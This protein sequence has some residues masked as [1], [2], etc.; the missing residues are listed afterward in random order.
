M[1]NYYTDRYNCFL[2]NANCIYEYLSGNYMND[3][4]GKLLDCGAFNNTINA[5]KISH[6]VQYRKME[7]DQVMLDT[8]RGAVEGYLSSI[9]RNNCGACFFIVSN[10]CEVKLYFAS[11]TV[12]EAGFDSVLKG[13]IPDVKTNNSFVSR[14]DLKR[15]ARYGGIVTG[16]FNLRRNVIDD[17]LHFIKD[18]EAIIGF[19]AKPLNRDISNRYCESLT[20]LHDLASSFGGVNDS[21]G[22]SNRINITRQFP[23]VNVLKDYTEKQYKRL[24]QNQND[25]WESCLWLGSFNEYHAKE[26]GGRLSG[27]LT[28]ADTECVERGRFF[29][30]VDNPLKN[31]Q[32]AISEACY[33]DLEYELSTY[34]MK[35]SLKSWI[36]T[37]EL[38]SMFQLPTRS[39][40]GINVI[41]TNKTV[42]DLSLFDSN[43]PSVSGDSFVFANEFDTNQNYL[44][45]YD[46]FTEHALITGGT[47]SGKTNTVKIL[48]E[49]LYRKNIP[50]CVIEPSKKEYWKMIGTIVNF[51]IFSSGLDAPM[52][53]LNPLEPED[54]II[55]GNH[56]DD[57]MYA[58]S[59]AFDMEEPTRLT[60]DGLIK[61][62]YQKAGWALDEI[63]YRQNKRYPI[64]KDLY[65]NLEEFSKFGIRSG[66]EVKANI[67]GSVLRR[68]ESLTTGTVGNITNTEYG[69]TGK[70][71]TEGFTLVELDDLSLD[72]KPFITNLLLIK[73]NQYLRQGDSSRG[74]LKNI[75]VLEE[76]HNVIPEPS[77]SGIETSKDISS[78]FF[79]NMLSQIRDYGTGLIIADQGAS[80]INSNAIANTKIKIVHALAKEQDADAEAFALRLNEMQKKHLPELD[81]GL[82]LVAVRGQDSVCKVK[83]KV[84]NVSHYNNFACMFCGQ[85]RFCEID[86]V[87]EKL[88]T[89]G[90]S[91][92]LLSKVYNNRFNAAMIRS[93]INAYFNSLKLSDNLRSCALGYMMANG[94]NMSGGEREKRRIL[95]RYLMQLGI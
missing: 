40:M 70:E 62:T 48:L 43:V 91:E 37:S 46:D 5:V 31:G 87:V 65:E 19:I 58:L 22:T 81:T 79:S 13:T 59:G 74:R 7:N 94:N 84:N 27:L 18:K 56:I 15:M 2:K 82:A 78:R 30:T 34:L 10:K 80:Q 11:E 35:G 73:M 1:A 14:D 72:I 85:R 67:E 93:D 23:G 32:L 55:I 92:L 90:R 88:Q 63:A 4:E 20:D 8:F 50:F 44:F 77:K 33:E 47:G 89:A 52:L 64:L 51:R 83:V 45:S 76:A 86:E 25:L 17:I 29:L 68:L 3:I 39:H 24:V 41:N 6:V 54:G 9:H 42:N 61:Y 75:I 57:L 16:A 49:N 95:F 53:K 26:I 71:L 28:A 12:N 36:T 38:A 69:I 66:A 21:F 60:F